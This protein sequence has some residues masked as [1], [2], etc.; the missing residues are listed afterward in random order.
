MSRATSSALNQALNAHSHGKRLRALLTLTHATFGTKRLVNDTRDV[1]SRGNTYTSHPF[2]GELPSDAEGPASGTFLV[3]AIDKAFSADLRGAK[4]AIT[5]LLEAVRLDAPD[6]V[7]A[8]AIFETRAREYDD[9]AGT[10]QLDCAH[11]PVQDEPYPGPTYD[12][13]RAPDLFVEPQ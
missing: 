13:Q 4:T 6:T 3:D 12:P 5:V 10:I 7:E 2:T 1:V 9:E 11:E 8:S